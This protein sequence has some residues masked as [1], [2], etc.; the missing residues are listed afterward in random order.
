[1][2]F[3][4]LDVIPMEHPKWINV[5]S[6]KRAYEDEY[7]LA[8]LG[9]MV[10][11]GEGAVYTADE[12]IGGDTLRYTH[13]TYGLAFRVTEEM[14]ED[15]LYGVMNR[16]SKELAKSASY[17]K[18][19]QATSVL[20]NAFNSSFTGLNGLELCSLVQ[21]DLDGGTQSNEPTTPV[22]MDLPAVQAAIEAFHSWTDD[23][24][25]QIQAKP[26]HLIHATGDIWMANEILKTEQVPHS[27]DNTINVVKSMFGLTPMHLRHLTDADAWFMTGSK[28]DHDMKMWM[29]V[30]DQ[31]RN[32]D[33]P[34]NGD[35]IFTARHRLST[36]FGDW[37]N[38]YG[39]PGA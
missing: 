10:Q 37:R 34:W 16:M 22:D 12:P 17:N 36:G 15:D 4:E 30:N 23:R 5:E 18:D 24:S 35:A 8:G 28:S 39:S 1:M 7:K 26:M 3:D 2:F 27:A 20:N 14:L 11:K 29:R 38:V 33:D 25:F 19:V 6:S 32:S 21:S 13:L 31:F 9:Q